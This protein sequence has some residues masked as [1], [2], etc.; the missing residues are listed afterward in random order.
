MSDI[1]IQNLVKNFKSVRVLQN[2]SLDIE[3]GSFTILL[4]P[5]GCGKS[6]LLR[7]ISGLESPTS[8]GIS[9]G[10]RE[11]TKLEPR[12]RDVAMVFQNYAL[13]P[14]LNVYQNIEYGLKARKVPKAEREKLI[15]DAVAM[16]KLQ[17]Q[18][19]KR[20]AQ[21]SGGQRQRVALARAIV[22]RPKAFLMDEPLSNLDAKLRGQMRGELLELHRRLQTTFLYVTHDQVEAMSM[23]SH[24][25]IL[26]QGK[27][28][29]QGTPRA[30]YEDPSNIFVA[31]FIGSPPANLIRLGNFYYAIR[32][33]YLSLDGPDESGITLT[34][35]ILSNENLGNE[36]IYN[37][38][39]PLGD[40]RMKTKN[41]WNENHS[42][43]AMHCKAR[44]I[45]CF[46][47]NGGRLRDAG[48][49]G[50]ALRS[51][52]E[53]TAAEK[54]SSPGGFEAGIRHKREMRRP[55][56]TATR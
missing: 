30:I 55:D 31:G 13:Y 46:D 15:R 28:Q 45:L 53:K 54:V 25:V 50:S 11:V 51:L 3:D 5:S 44:N 39:T 18:V 34:G 10:G 6:T 49:C 12:D 4:G 41:I 24:I 9:I 8:G 35:R 42:S 2:I 1:R 47:E 43:V 29:Q 17:D 40:L 27:I 52:A 22:K 14:H 21:M 26:D 38:R 37:V 16:V 32:P 7:L 19:L 23:G 36:S 20:P 56:Q 48:Q 33:E